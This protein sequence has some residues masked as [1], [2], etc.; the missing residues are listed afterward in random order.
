MQL[1]IY[2]NYNRMLRVAHSD[3]HQQRIED[4]KN[5]MEEVKAER[6]KL[7][8]HAEGESLS[9][10]DIEDIYIQVRGE[11]REKYNFSLNTRNKTGDISDYLEAR[12]PF[13][14]AQWKVKSWD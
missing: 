1:D 5:R 7:L 4:T 13:G 8:N 6:T 12:R 11:E 9:I 10:D 14:A 2:D 3:G